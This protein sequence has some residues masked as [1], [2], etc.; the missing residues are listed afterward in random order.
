VAAD[1]DQRP[2][3]EIPAIDRVGVVGAGFMGSGIAE[4]VARSGIDVVLHEPDR[5]PL[6]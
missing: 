1:D 4:A 6:E 5:A 3:N 2:S